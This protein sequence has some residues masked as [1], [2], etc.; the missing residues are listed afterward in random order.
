MRSLLLDGKTGSSYYDGLRLE[1]AGG[2][3]EDVA[4]VVEPT[5]FYRRKSGRLAEVTRSP[6]RS[7]PAGSGARCFSRRGFF[8]GDRQV[9]CRRF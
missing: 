6:V 2:A 5:V 1:K 8:D 7:Q 4:A 3:L 9:S